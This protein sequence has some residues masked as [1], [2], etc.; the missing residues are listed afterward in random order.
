MAELRIAFVPGVTP[1]KWLERWRERHP[2]V[3]VT[4]TRYDDGADPR[5][6]LASGDAD[7]VFLRFD[8]GVKPADAT[9]HVIPLYEELPVVCAPREHEVELYDDEVPW[10]ELDGQ[11]WLDL[12]DY[13][14][15][16]GGTA[17]AVEVVG[18]GAGL[19]VLPMSVG[20]LY[21]RK[22]VVQKILTGVPSTRI[23][24]AWLKP[25]GDEPEDPQVEEFIGIVRGRGANSSRQPS[26][27]ERE[28]RE[29][30]AAQRKRQRSPQESS[31]GGARTSGKRPGG[32][33]T[34]SKRRG[35]P[36]RGR[37]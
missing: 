14:P 17:M 18:T 13:P 25:I 27:Q 29:A 34:G 12:A 15:A 4:A 8:D 10:S 16:V 37:R 26:V 20:R 31:R 5:G 36:A 9:T 22:D 30:D 28:R 6:L 35:G 7:L 21:R 2:E 3:P 11:T 19:L 24:V 1:G 33:S 23:G 32:G